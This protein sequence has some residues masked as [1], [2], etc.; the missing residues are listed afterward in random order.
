M[1]RAC[2]RSAGCC[3]GHAGSSGPYDL[4][5]DP[6]ELVSERVTLRPGEHRP[7]R[8]AEEGERVRDDGGERRHHEHAKKDPQYFDHG[9]MVAPPPAWR[10]RDTT[11]SDTRV[12]RWPP[13]DHG[14]GP[15]WFHAGCFSPA[16]PAAA[17][18]GT[19]SSSRREG[20]KR[21][22]GLRGPPA[23][24]PRWHRPGGP[25]WAAGDGGVLQGL[26]SQRSGLL[27]AGPGPRCRPHSGCAVGGPTG[28]RL[29]V[30]CL[31]WGRHPS[32][33]RVFLE[34]W[35]GVVYSGGK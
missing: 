27:V 8:D 22:R 9:S 15:G 26:L 14:G 35:G 4:G 6:V 13:W 24:S 16:G 20:P 2:E 1:S 34:W 11:G 12:P 31:W 10:K 3:R 29:H 23:R 21:T 25:R 18:G 30:K 28:G 17:V 5:E 19:R 7:G 33:T 32:F